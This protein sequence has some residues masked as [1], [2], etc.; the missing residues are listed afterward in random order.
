MSKKI[1]ITAIVLF[2][3]D[4]ITKSFIS[5]YLTLNQSIKVIK[6][7]FYI[8]YINN[9]GASFGMLKN[10]K[11]FLIILSLI[12]IIIILRY[13]NTFKKTKLN[14]IGF[15]LVLGG[16]LGNLSDRI[17]F[18]YVIDF[19]DFFIFS[20]NFPVFNFADVFIVI[21]V[22][23]LIISIL[24]GEDQNGSKSSRRSKRKTR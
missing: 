20:Y 15:S 16:I 21:G 4:Q 23:L 3:I 17:L 1:Y 19:F 11:L 9:S 18:G 8:T 13:M 7:F 10:S 5:T 14:M 2:I 12:A 6:D 24:R 22:I